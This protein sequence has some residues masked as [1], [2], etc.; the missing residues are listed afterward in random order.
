MDILVTG[1]AG[2]I[3]SHLCDRL[4]QIGHR[5]ICVDNFL[6][7]SRFNLEEAEK[8][9]KRFILIKGD[10]N[11]YI[12]LEGIF[13]RY[14]I[15][16]VFHLAAVVGVKRTEEN[17]FLVLEDINGIKNILELSSKYRVKR[18]VYTS[19]SE[20]YGRS[21]NLPSC[22]DGQINPS[23]TYA[24][25]KLIGEKFCKAYYEKHHLKT[26]CLRLF[27]IYGPRQVH[28]SYGFVAA[29]FIKRALENFDIEIFGDGKQARDFTYIEDFLNCAQII[30][31]HKFWEGGVINIGTGVETSINSLAK[32]IIRLTKSKS[33][34]RHLPL[35]TNEISSRCADINRMRKVLKYKPMY[36]ISSGIEQTVS[37]HRLSGCKLY[38][39]GG[40]A[41]RTKK[42]SY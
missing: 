12:L 25:V 4:L 23:I 42:Y 27:N 32:T 17:P 36:N 11:N 30:L 33:K 35:R 20:V 2:F 26:C 40:K 1:G 18:F 22:E 10:V 5:V 38:R 29:I 15:D 6:T 21:F 7:G 16:I 8:F 31:S 37:W 9:K 14:P 24:A 28:S 13:K 34:I 3:G 39:V 19:S 41:K